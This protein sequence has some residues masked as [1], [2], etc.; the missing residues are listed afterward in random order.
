MTEQFAYSTDDPEIVA[1]YRQAVAE[2]NAF[3]PRIRADVEAL[4]AGPRVMVR[5]SAF[6]GDRD[7]VVALEQSGDHVPDGWRV[8]RGNLEPRRGKRGEAARQWLADHQPVDVRHV[9]EQHGLPRA[10]WVSDPQRGWTH[11]ICKPALFE[12][13][14]TLWACYFGEPGKSGSGFDE[15]PCTWTRRKLS[16]FYAAEEAFDAA[17]NAEAVAA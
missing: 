17:R 9:M 8:V 7:K 13:E 5:S 10:S 3:G 16:E 14:G 15:E 4:G 11:K 6:P 1:A 12:H 2:R